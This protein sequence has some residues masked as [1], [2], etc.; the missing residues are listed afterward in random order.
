M[1]S[2]DQ[3]TLFLQNMLKNT[4]QTG[5]VGSV[6]SGAISSA[7]AQG[8]LPQFHGSAAASLAP[9]MLNLRVLE[10]ENERMVAKDGGPSPLVVSSFLPENLPFSK[11]RVQRQNPTTPDFLGAEDYMRYVTQKD[12]VDKKAAEPGLNA[13]A[14]ATSPVINNGW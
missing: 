6:V 3:Q 5:M 1:T 12:G 14:S 8:Y 7:T 13:V 10:R 2:P 9:A 11:D 4:T